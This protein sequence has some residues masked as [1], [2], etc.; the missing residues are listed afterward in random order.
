MIMD[1]K[2]FPR[3]Y[4][5]IK[6]RIRQKG[7][8]HVLLWPVRRFIYRRNRAIIMERTLEPLL[9]K[10]LVSSKYVTSRFRHE[11]LGSLETYF[12]E[13][14]QIFEGFLADGSEGYGIHEKNTGSAVCC[15]WVSTKPYFD[16]YHYQLNF[17]TIDRQIYQFAIETA[18]PHRGSRATM[19]LLDYAYAHYRDL[20]YTSTMACVDEHNPNSHKWHLNMGFKP[21]GQMFDIYHLL[22]FRFHRKLKTQPG[23][24]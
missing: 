17:N 3:L 22:G 21:N 19:I 16:K 14:R 10:Q 8:T 20:G 6:Q 5:K 15:F 13:K 12:P 18:A 9:R 24:K 7:L 2:L 11:H 1:D 4:T 23:G